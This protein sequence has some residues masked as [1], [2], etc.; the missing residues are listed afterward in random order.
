MARYNQ[1]EFDPYAQDNQESMFTPPPVYGQGG[2]A[3]DPVGQ[4]KPYN[5]TDP[6]PVFSVAPPAPPQPYN[7]P[8]AS[9]NTG[10]YA[11]V[12]GYDTGK[13]SDPTHRGPGKYNNDVGLFSQGL[14]ALNY[15]QGSGF[16]P[17][18]ATLTELTNWMNAHGG[19]VT[20]KGD[21]MT[22]TNSLDAAGRPYTIDVA[23]DYNPGGGSGQ[24]SFQDPRGNPNYN[25][26]TGQ[27]A[28][29]SS[30]VGGGAGA[31]TPGGM[32]TLQLGGIL[33]Q[34]GTTQP[35]WVSKGLQDL[36]N[37]NME[38]VNNPLGSAQFEALRQPIDKARRTTNNQYAAELASRG[39]LTGSGE[40]A[41]A[42][43]RNEER[44]APAFATAVQNASAE[45]QNAARTGALGALQGGTQWSQVQGN[46]ALGQLDQNR[47]WNQFLADFGLRRDQVQ[48]M[49]SQG[50]VDQLL[51]YY[52]IWNNANQT[53]AN[54]FIK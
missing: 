9:S 2:P 5:P 17:S 46:L 35:E 47:Q 45:N 18:E 37:S 19:N 21:Q 29:P 52:E 20:R 28:P 15:G 14:A 38:S 6:H 27:W 1:D 31:Q 34:G 12:G 25:I 39:I 36:F 11:E 30:G 16:T 22:F 41:N 3:L 48:E 50:R 53:S 10:P 32:S 26:D 54:G 24:F 42:T 51:H 8:A 7:P 23:Q 49:L 43:G 13:L 40:F 33:G 4:P 44:L